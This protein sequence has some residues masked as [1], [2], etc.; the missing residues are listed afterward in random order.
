[1]EIERGLLITGER[2]ARTTK[3][4]KIFV[5]E[6]L[7]RDWSV[8]ETAVNNLV[9]AAHEGEV[10]EIY[11]ALRVLDIGYHDARSDPGAGPDQIQGVHAWDRTASLSSVDVSASAGKL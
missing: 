4:S 8:L 2:G 5:V 3:H 1:V 9:Q 6:A 7:D 11:A 10:S